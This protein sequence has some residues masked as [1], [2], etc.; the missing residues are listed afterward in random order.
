LSLT[1]VVIF[2]ALI[3]IGLVLVVAF[4]FHLN[5]EEQC[6]LS[7]PA[8]TVQEGYYLSLLV[9]NIT[10]FI[11]GALNPAGANN[12]NFNKIFYICKSL[13]VSLG[14]YLRVE[15]HKGALVEKALA[16]FINLALLKHNIPCF[17]LVL[18]L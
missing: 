13:W 10:K 9:D 14:A 18:P 4:F 2:L 15:H 11:Y 8:E 17:V 7:L 5:H 6:D 16:L 3:I 12:F 1:F